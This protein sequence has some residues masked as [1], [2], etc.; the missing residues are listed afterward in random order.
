MRMPKTYSL[1]PFLI[2]VTP[3]GVAAFAVLFKYVIANTSP[4]ELIIKEQ[5]AFDLMAGLTSQPFSRLPITCDWDKTY[6]I[7]SDKIRLRN[8]NI[9][10]LTFSNV[11]EQ[12]LVWTDVFRTPIEFS[13]VG[14]GELLAVVTDPDPNNARVRVEY[15]RGAG[16][17]SVSADFLNP[18]SSFMLTVYHTSSKSP[19]LTVKGR[20]FNHPRLAIE[21]S[22]YSNKATNLWN[23]LLGGVLIGALFAPILTVGD[24]VVALFRRRRS[25]W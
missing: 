7:Q 3:F 8:L 23:Y 18:G 24:H 22:D 9:V 2:T 14:S 21:R 15:V 25:R 10:A 11:G 12:P 13:T 20:V 6:G 4:G 5:Y 17:F 19:R 16:T 1:K